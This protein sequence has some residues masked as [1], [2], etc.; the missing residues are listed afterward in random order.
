L[1]CFSSL[2]SR[3]VRFARTGVL[4]GFMIFLIATACPVSWSF[5]ELEKSSADRAWMLAITNTYQTSPNAPIPTG[6][7]SAYLEVKS[8]VAGSPAVPASDVPACYLKRRPENLGA[9]KL[10]HRL[11]RLSLLEGATAGIVR[12]YLD[13]TQA[14][15]MENVQATAAGRCCRTL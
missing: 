6:W 3:Y 10:R 11:C 12:E 8:A 15:L 14:R 2:S 4:K 9:D 5:A 7:R 1:R 13:V